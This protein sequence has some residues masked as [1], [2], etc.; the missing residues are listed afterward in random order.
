M[1]T[2]SLEHDPPPTPLQKVRAIWLGLAVAL[3]PIAWTIQLLLLTA[4]SNYTCF[5]GETQ[6]RAPLQ[7][8]VHPLALGVDV[9]ALLAALISASIAWRYLRDHIEPRDALGRLRL[10]RLHFVAMGGLLSGLGFFVAILFETIATLMVPPC[11]G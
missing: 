1:S 8:W 3:P 6:V 2:Q 7:P 4:L 11:T 9:L 10:G 5:P